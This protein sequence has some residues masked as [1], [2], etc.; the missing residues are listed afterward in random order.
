[1]D[2]VTG[3]PAVSAR[4]TGEVPGSVSIRTSA[5]RSMSPRRAGSPCHEPTS[6]ALPSRSTSVTMQPSV[7]TGTTSSASR[8]SADSVSTWPDSSALTRASSAVRAVVRRAAS[9]ASRRCETSTT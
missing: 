7:R 1:M 8:P 6:R 5:Y 3:V 4:A 2:S 9:A